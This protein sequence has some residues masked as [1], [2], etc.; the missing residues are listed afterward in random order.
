[1]APQ[2]NCGAN[3]LQSQICLSELLAL[4]SCDMDY[5]TESSQKLLHRE[6]SPLSFGCVSGYVRGSLAST[7]A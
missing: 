2:S 5:A 7:L 1:M 3:A 6:S 4:E